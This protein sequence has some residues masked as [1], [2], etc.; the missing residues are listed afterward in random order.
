MSRAAF[1]ILLALVLY[2]AFGRA[3]VAT[4]PEAVIA[5]P[6]AVS[7][8][9]ERPDGERLHIVRRD[10]A[11]RFL[12]AAEV[13]GQGTA[14]LVDTG[15]DTVALTVDEADRLGLGVDPS[16]FQPI[17]ESASGTAYGTTVTL[18]SLSVAGA[19][20][21]DVRAMVIDG[22]GQNLLGQSVLRR[23]GR[24]ELHE[25]RMEIRRGG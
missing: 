16:A 8:R 1:L 17:A 21:H 24:I 5:G 15:A 6:A 7:S 14:F 20:F 19:E 4:A 25:D 2:A 13:N 18:D 23:L 11:G 12:I 3:P 9:P 22:L 10:D